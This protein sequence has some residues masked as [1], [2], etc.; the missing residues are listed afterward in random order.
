MEAKKKPF[1]KKKIC[2]IAVAVLLLLA[3]AAALL[4]RPFRTSLPQSSVNVVS[5]VLS[6]T[7][8]LGSLTENF[9]SGGT[10]AAAESQTVSLAGNI[11]L[12]GWEVSDGDYVESGTLLATVEK[13][14]VLSA[15][16]DVNDM[17]TKLDAAI[18]ESRSDT[19]A[20]SVTAPTAGRVKA[21]FAA[22]G[23]SVTDVM[24]ENGALALLS[25]D[26]CMAVDIED[27]SLSLGDALT[28]TL[29][30][31]TEL[32]GSVYSISESTAAVTVPDTKAE[33]GDTVTVSR[34]G[35]EIGRGMLRI[36]AELAVMGYEGT[37]SSVNVSVNSSVSAGQQLFYVTDTADTSRY[38]SLT[39]QRRTLSEKL[40]EL[41][42][43]YE[44]GGIYAETAGCISGINEDIVGTSADTASGTVSGAAPTTGSFKM[45]ISRALSSARAVLLSDGSADDTRT[46][47]GEADSPDSSEQ[48]DAPTDSSA[49]EEPS[50]PTEP[51]VAKEYIG[52]VSEIR[53]NEDGTVT[54]VISVT[55]GSTLEVKAEELGEKAAVIRTG[56]LLILGY[57]E[58]G[59]LVNVS[60]Y[61]DAS[62]SS[63]EQEMPTD[64][65]PD[66][67][68][69]GMSGFGGGVSAVSAEEEEEDYTVSETELCTLTPYDTAEIILSVD[70]LDIAGLSVGQ[71]AAVTLDALADQTFTGTISEID[72]NGSYSGGDT[73]YTVTV[74][75]ERTA[76]MLEGMNASVTVE[77]EKHDG[78][79]LIPAAAVSESEDGTFVYTDTDKNGDPTDAAAVTTGLSDGTNVEILSGL[80]EGDSYYYTYASS[81][82]YS[83]K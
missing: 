60:V 53:Q 82:E 61:Q 49:S 58:D 65:F 20:S 75:M 70:E 13:N 9:I 25:L 34:D 77:L 38:E 66:A 2:I 40:Q 31:G 27:D 74:R 3:I 33:Y 17:L 39:E 79:L 35:E 69:S 32:E 24:Y 59:T 30:D 12:T 36:N 71:T 18:E 23:D 57:A 6:G 1:T 10:I 50:G 73:K 55:D 80:S 21:V 68:I 54:Y 63:G 46:E 19:V 11:K 22:S 42:T 4:L 37:V 62:S 45:L 56:D 43:V 81:L 26:G 64:S 28:V 72:P 14:S 5:E 29:S 41:F 7:A 47:S 51:T 78:I 16:S 15:I 52:R 8:Q 48:P 44:K 83:F 76:D 67:D